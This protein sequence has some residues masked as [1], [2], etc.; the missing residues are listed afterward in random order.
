MHSCRLP[1]R[2][3]SG[4]QLVRDSPDDIK[5]RLELRAEARLLS[6]TM[7]D[8]DKAVEGAWPRNSV[9]GK[10]ASANACMHVYDAL[11]LQRRYQTASATIV[12][13]KGV[14]GGPL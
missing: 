13:E 10:P 14:T 6:L 11:K 2:T 8:L 12:A 1:A 4:R 5:C 9:T 7:P 3:E